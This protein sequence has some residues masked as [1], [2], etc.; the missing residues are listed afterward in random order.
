MS[1]PSL[2]GDMVSEIESLSRHA[3]GQGRLVSALERELADAGA[4]E[5]RLC[6]LVQQQSEEL[7]NEKREHGYTMLLFEQA[8]GNY[9][10]ADQ[11]AQERE[12]RILAL[13]HENERLKD[14]VPQWVPVSEAP[15]D[16]NWY[17]FLTEN[18]RQRVDRFHESQ[19][20]VLGAPRWHEL[21]ADRYT[22]WT[23]LLPRPHHE[24]NNHV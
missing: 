7:A 17:L 19:G 24:E 16:R 20:C 10:Q 9:K 14:L 3:A 21:P 11:C 23:P 4:R 2:R 6:A 8:V 12:G 13:L 1:D 15:L 18:G 5:Q 22:H